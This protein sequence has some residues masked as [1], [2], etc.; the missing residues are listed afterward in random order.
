[1]PNICFEV[2]IPA[3]DRPELLHRAIQSLQAQDYPHWRAV[4]YDDSLSNEVEDLVQSISDSRI[5]YSRNNERLGAAENIDRCFSPTPLYQGNYG[6][7]L[8][9]DNFWLRGFLA[10]LVTRLSREP[11]D[12]VLANQRI[13]E[14]GVGLRP[15]VHTTRAGWFLGGMVEPLELRATL[16]FMEGLSNGG[17]VWRLGG[18]IDLRVGPTVRETG[19]HEACRSLL[20]ARPFFFL[21]EPQ[22]A[23]TLMPKKETARSTERNRLISRG[24]QSVMRFVLKSQGVALVENATRIA[25]RM[26]LIDRLV[27]GV[28][29][30]GHPALVWGLRHCRHQLIAAAYCKGMAVRIAEK[31]PCALFLSSPRPIRWIR[32]P[33]T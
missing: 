5:H 11:W 32:I 6:C 18:N 29:R 17:L 27:Q 1:M 12:V 2:R 23:W 16:L 31:D 30:S 14:Q 8:E 26:G 4:V 25:A 15:P 13:Y 10:L 21:E 20:L 9:D 33:R 28:A 19:L 24:R 7:L 22:A 3:F